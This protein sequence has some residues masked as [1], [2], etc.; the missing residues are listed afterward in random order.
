MYILIKTAHKIRRMR[1]NKKNIY[2]YIPIHEI[3]TWSAS[4][5][6]H[7]YSCRYTCTTESFLSYE[8]W[9][10]KMDGTKIEN[11]ARTRKTTI[12]DFIFCEQRIKKTVTDAHAALPKHKG[13]EYCLLFVKQYF[14]V[15]FFFLHV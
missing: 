13:V 4:A 12:Y 10:M 7:G 1:T 9:R 11:I 3:V 2:I 14:S 8:E 6:R 15:S 5:E